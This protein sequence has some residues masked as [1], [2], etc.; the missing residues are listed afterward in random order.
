M[1]SAGKR[2]QARHTACMEQVTTF[3]VPLSTLTK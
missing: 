3:N 1:V 2:L